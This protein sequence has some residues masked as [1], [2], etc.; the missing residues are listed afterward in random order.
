MSRTPACPLALCPSPS[1]PTE[2]NPLTHPLGKRLVLVIGEMKTPGQ[3]KDARGE[4][5]NKFDEGKKEGK[6]GYPILH[7]LR[8]P[9]AITKEELRE[10]FGVDMVK[11]RQFVT[12]A[13]AKAWPTKNLL[14]LISHE[15]L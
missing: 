2:T 13:L 7:V 14:N 4:G 5:N 6:F 3:V 15:H 10:D 12:K 11:G 1:P 8:L 9:H